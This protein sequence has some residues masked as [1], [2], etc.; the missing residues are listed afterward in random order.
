MGTLVND[1]LTNIATHAYTTV[2]F[3]RDIIKDEGM[4]A[5]KLSKGDFIRLPLIDK[6]MVLNSG[7]NMIS[8]YNTGYDQRKNLLVRRTSGSSGHYLKVYWN[9]YDDIRSMMGLWYRRKQY[10][11]VL[12]TE[13]CC[14]FYTTDYVWNKFVDEQEESLSIDGRLLG[15]SKKNLNNERIL[16]IYNRME[17]FLPTWI[18]MQPSIALI[19]TN[20]IKYF[21]LPKF[22]GLKMIELSGEYLT[23]EMREDIA[24]A[25]GCKVANQYG[26]IEANSIA[27]ECG[28][29]LLAVQSANVYVE[30][31]RDGKVQ[32][33]GEEGDIYITSLVNQAMPF[34]RYRIGERG[35]L[36]PA[37]TSDY[38][39]GSDILKLLNGRTS[40]SVLTESFDKIPSYIFLEPI[41]YINER[42]GNIIRQFQV[43]Q[44][45]INKF[46]VYLVIRS[47][48]TNWENA[49]K[50][51]FLERLQEEN[52]NKASFK[53]V[54]SDILLP[55][56]VTGKLN[57]FISEV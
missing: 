19:L 34:V 40:S 45:E 42:I 54:F 41:E 1:R 3:Y 21:H 7:L 25:F 22:K 36:Y 17:K 2:P 6:G 20:K 24:E 46:T 50:E 56:S 49:I 5:F 13:R 4:D 26:C 37:G 30:I 15:F 48:Y 55:D 33:Y 8:K 44:E 16:G 51:I 14:F 9:N 47:A 32:P 31:V 52:L 12:P 38:T 18:M 35:I 10:Y 43:V 23:E 27:S 11:D 39:G 28:G 29:K 53:F 57:Y